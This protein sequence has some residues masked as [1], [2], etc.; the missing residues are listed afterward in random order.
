MEFSRKSPSEQISETMER[1]YST[2]MTTASGGNISIREKNGNIW[3]TPSGVDKGTLSPQDIV[4]VKK[5]GDS[6][7]KFGYGPT[8]ELSSHRAV[9]RKR[10][11]LNAIIHAHPSA[12]LTFSIAR[13]VPN[14]KICPQAYN[15]CGKIGYAPYKISGSNALALSVSNEFEKGHNCVVMENHAII[16]GGSCL[17][18]AF[19][20]LETLEY[21]ART[22]INS[23]KL[24]TYDTLSTD[25][26]NAYSDRGGNLPEQDDTKYPSNDRKIREEI[27]KIVKRAYRQ[28]LMISTYGTVS[29]RWKGNDFLI[30]PTDFDRQKID[31]QDIVQIRN[32]KREIG[33]YPSRSA[34]LHKAIY[35]NN[36]EIN[37]IIISQPPNLLSF[38]I[39]GIPIDTRISP[40]SYVLLR[41]IPLVPYGK[42]FKNGIDIVDK[43]SPKTPIVQIQNDAIVV[44]GKSIFEAFDRLEVTEYTAKSLLDNILMQ[45]KY[46]IEDNH[47]KELENK[48][49]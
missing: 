11:D 20:R 34:R 9:Y 13:E 31:N 2:G 17:A 1:I 10:K 14:T 46:S 37:S 35:E 42:Q 26:I 49:L 15:I 29:I 8:S 6:Q 44:T 41:T 24:N 22:I 47:L 36:S 16:V 25:Q 33:K 40:E 39:S 7:N 38:C 45:E 18:E 5:E 43:L 23:L 19:R 12:L 32:G 48:F 30:T 28:H 27:C 4:C 3:T 21:C